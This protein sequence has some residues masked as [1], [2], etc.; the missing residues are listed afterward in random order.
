MAAHADLW[1]E[2]IMRTDP[3]DPAVIVPA[4]KGLYGVA[5]LGEPRVVVVP[6]PLV[7]YLAGG[8]AAAW[9]YVTER[10]DADA[11]PAATDAA[12][13]AATG[14][15]T[16]AAT[17]VATYVATDAAT[18]AATD[19]ATDAATYAATYDATGAATRVATLVAT[20]A[21]T[22]AA[23]HVATDAATYA[24]T[25]D[26]TDDA[27]YA[28]TDAATYD[29]TYAATGAATY[30]ATY[31]A[32]RAATYAATDAAT[33]AATRAATDAATDDATRAAT[34]DATRAATDD[35][36][37]AATHVA[38]YA[39]THVATRAATHAATDDATYDATDAATDAATYDATRAATYA[40]TRDATYDA[41]YAATYDATLVA[42][43]DATDAATRAATDG[44]R[45][46]LPLVQAI[47][48]GYERLAIECIRNAHR[49]YQGGNMWGQYD[50]YLTAARDILGL[51]LPEHEK[52][53]WWEE[54]AIHGGWRIMHP[55]FCMVS[56]FPEV[57]LKDEQ[58]RPHC[59]MGPSHRWRDGFEIY[60]L[61]GVRL[62][63]ELHARITSGKMTAAEVIQ[64]DD[65]DVRALALSRLGATELHHHL[66]GELVHTGIRGTRLYCVADFEGTGEREWYTLKTD[67]STGREFVEF[68]PPG[69]GECRD[70]DQCEAWLYDVP[71]ELYLSVERH[72]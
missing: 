65:V 25:R 40:A 71:V 13:D 35:A 63:R 47:L 27:T 9:W 58:N 57:L 53:R 45:W 4:I 14:A 68:V 11:T 6:S 46:L 59:E 67:P 12:T 56:D 24:A 66:G 43:Y 28:A 52:Y 48:P 64:I 29:A 30:D 39:A 31:A 36:T 17:L 62:T 23:T 61:D 72:G 8:L 34:D 3:I 37:R 10:G 54:A 2:R 69:V 41:T 33:R 16:G 20:G 44:Y 7:A 26:A 70:A 22:D 32:T 18:R 19:V 5:G 55:R 21:A 42:T 15:A 1:I 49:M 60:H 51:R 50:A 38:T